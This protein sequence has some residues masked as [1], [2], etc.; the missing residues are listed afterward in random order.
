MLTGPPCS[1]K[2]TV[3]R[4]LADDPEWSRHR[5]MHIEVDALFEL[6]LPR[7]DRSRE[8][9][10]LAYEAAHCLTRMLVE[11]GRLVVLECTYAR[12]E[13]RDSLLT[14]LAALPQVPLWAVEFIISP[15]EAARRF[16][17]RTAATDL[18]ERLVRDRA[19]SFP[20]SAQALP[21][22]SSGSTP[23]GLAREITNWLRH[24]PRAVSRT[25]WAG[26]GRGWD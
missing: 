20:Y 4:I 23:D 22:T 9:R 17:H 19:A 1:G 6:L 12:Q 5:T 25:A 24:Q 21:L 26:T 13:Q 14:A 2:S 8:D 16:R 7:S 3:G 15:E 10:M 11:R 18:D